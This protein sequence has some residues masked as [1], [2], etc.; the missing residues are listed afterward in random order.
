MG[1]FILCTS[2]AAGKPYVFPLSEIKVYSIEELCY[3]IYHNIYEITS[4]C[5]DEKLVKWMRDELGMSVIAEKLDTMISINSSLKDIVVS[6]MCS[7]DYYSES[8]IKALLLLLN[9]IENLPFHGRQKI[10]ADY[11]LKYGKYARAKKEYDRIIYGGYAVNLTPVEYGNILHNRSLAC[12]NMGSYQEAAMGWKDAYGRNN[13]YESL[14]EYLI[15]LLLNGNTKE[16]EH[17]AANYGISE[18]E[19]LKIHDQV[20]NAFSEAENCDEYQAIKKIEKYA[21]VDEAV[22]YAVKKIDR[23]KV[24]YREGNS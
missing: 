3:Y 2:R 11:C 19:A 8:E 22:I 4:E 24:Q 23:W 6:I 10:K 5:F 18:T 21:S 14:R 15:A 13:S 9:E 1:K 12:Y 16:F 17:E 7:C 20:Q